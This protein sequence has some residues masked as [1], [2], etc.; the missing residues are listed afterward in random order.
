MVNILEIEII[1][2]SELTSKL[3]FLQNNIRLHLNKEKIFKKIKRIN[4]QLTKADAQYLENVFGENGDIC[5]IRASCIALDTKSIINSIF[6]SLNILL[7]RTDHLKLEKL[8]TIP[9]QILRREYL[10]EKTGK[11]IEQK[12]RGIVYEVVC[13]YLENYIEY[14]FRILSNKTKEQILIPIFK[15]HPHLS[16]QNFLLHKFYLSN[17]D[18][19]LED[20]TGQI[21]FYLNTT[22]LELTLNFQSKYQDEEFLKE[23][24]E[25][26]KYNGNINDFARLMI[27][28]MNY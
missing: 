26:Q 1:N 13:K 20:L 3:S 9:N 14:D 28:Y 23:W 15:G 18:I 17:D 22:S 5:H 24:V 7:K 6:W 12:D 10:F 27:T 19:I 2:E 11:T 4:I 16:A 8:N 25:A 21:K